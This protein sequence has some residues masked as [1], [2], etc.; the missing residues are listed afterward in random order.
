MNCPN[1]GSS[2]C[3]PMTETKSTD[4]D[5]VNACCGFLLWGPIGILCGLCGSG[6][7]TTKQYWKCGDCGRNF[8]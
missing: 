6:E 2:N 3:F 4:F 7:T 5:N 1:C 8:K